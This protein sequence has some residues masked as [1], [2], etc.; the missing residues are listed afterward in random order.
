MNG[1]G[2]DGRLSS[3]P[4]HGIRTKVSARRTDVKRREKLCKEHASK[5]KDRCNKNERE[6]HSEDV[7]INIV[8]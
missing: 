5:Y 8:W 6:E 7:V 2:G 1:S 3:N 4:W